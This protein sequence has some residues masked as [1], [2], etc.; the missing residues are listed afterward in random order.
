MNSQSKLHLTA[1]KVVGTPQLKSTGNYKF[2][3]S[4]CGNDY[5]YTEQHWD[6]NGQHIGCSPVKL[7][8]VQLNNEP[9][10][11]E[12]ESGWSNK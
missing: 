5:P 12:D 3:C 9:Y 4:G 2:R 6:I 7:K 1:K 11:V 8:S 10:L